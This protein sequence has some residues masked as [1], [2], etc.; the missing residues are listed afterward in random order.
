MLNYAFVNRTGLG[1]E[2]SANS[3]ED[4]GTFVFIALDCWLDDVGVP[5]EVH[6]IVLARAYRHYHE[7]KLHV[8]WSPSSHYILINP[9]LDQGFGT[10]RQLSNR[11]RVPFKRFYKH[12]RGPLD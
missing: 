10:V 3:V 11:V 12:G 4:T 7:A 8:S 2:I 5:I 1:N 6:F 9:N